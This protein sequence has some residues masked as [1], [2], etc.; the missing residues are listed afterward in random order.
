MLFLAFERKA[1]V[2]HRMDEID[3]RHDAILGIRLCLLSL[4]AGA[5]WGFLSTAL[6]KFSS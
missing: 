1:L 4:M 5:A 2:E 3:V 6:R